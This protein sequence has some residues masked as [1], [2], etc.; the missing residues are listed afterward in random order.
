MAE[1]IE[2][3]VAVSVPKKK[4]VKKAVNISSSRHMLSFSLKWKNI[5]KI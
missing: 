5:I 3:S 4:K 1:Y 2:V